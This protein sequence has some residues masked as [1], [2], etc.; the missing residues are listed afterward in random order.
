MNQDIIRSKAALRRDILRKR[1]QLDRETIQT[2]SLSI[3][4]RVL[5]F[6]REKIPM[7][8]DR[9]LTVMSYMSFGSEFPT[10]DLNRAIL[11]EGWRLV[12]PFTE[13]DFSITAC[14]TESLENLR[15]SRMGIPEP[16]P[17]DSEQINASEIDLILLPGIAFDLSGMR[18]GYGKGCYDR[19]LSRSAGSLPPILALS[20]S[21][22]VVETVPSED[23][24]H[25]FDYLITEREFIPT[26][27]RSF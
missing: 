17:D 26:V 10:T 20:W 3:V 15:K 16:D 6:I 9:P 11:E 12:L 22:Q 7:P 18:L 19:F 1:R 24:D 21:F 4:P 23:H 14:V 8:S 13:N 2:V 25:F 27:R 5:N